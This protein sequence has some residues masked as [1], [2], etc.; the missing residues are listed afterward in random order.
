MKKTTQTSLLPKE[1]TLY[2]YFGPAPF[3]LDNKIC[4][5][6]SFTGKKSEVTLFPPTVL[7]D[8]IKMGD[9]GF[10]TGKAF[11]DYTHLKN[12]EA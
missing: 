12:K 9:Q 4:I 1:K 7:E 8:F 6:L 11:I 2:D 5:V 3:P 10:L